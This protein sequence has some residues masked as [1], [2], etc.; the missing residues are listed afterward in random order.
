VVTGGD[1]LDAASPA[2]TTLLGGAGFDYMARWITAGETGVIDGG[3][4][5]DQLELLGQ[6]WLDRDP[7]GALDAET[8][9]AVI[10]AGDDTHTT[11]FSSVDY[12]TLWG[13]PWTFRGTE[14]DDFVQILDDRLDAQGMGGDDYLLGG[15]QADVLDGG[16]GADQG[17]GGR[18]QNTCIDTEAGDCSGYPWDSTTTRARVARL[19]TTSPAR[20][21][22]HKLVSRWLNHQTPFVAH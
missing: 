20:V 10:T 13:T 16:E 19:P 2:H 17:W 15:D 9:T 6:V 18:G 8:S 11:A 4:D 1:W 22:P 12:F 14:A 7:S 5:D 3:A 21:A